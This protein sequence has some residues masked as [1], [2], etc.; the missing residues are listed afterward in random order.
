MLPNLK[1]SRQSPD[2]K[3]QSDCR[4]AV[5][6]AHD[7]TIHAGAT[8]VAVKP[9]RGMVGKF[10]RSMRVSPALLWL[11]PCCHVGAR[12]RLEACPCCLPGAPGDTPSPLHAGTLKSGIVPALC[13]L[14]VV[15]HS[16][17][18]AIASQPQM[19]MRRNLACECKCE[20]QLFGRSQGGLCRG[21]TATTQSPTKSSV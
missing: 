15:P 1:F 5:K 10:D 16:V 2:C 11:C 12:L 3:K 17:P 20:S 8:M 7:A 6:I 19:R 4:Q 13:C 14:I 18:A 9:I 21:P